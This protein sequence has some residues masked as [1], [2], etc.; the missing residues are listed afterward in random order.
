MNT[1]NFVISTVTKRKY[2]S[3]NAD[4]NQTVNCN[5]TNIVYLIT[6]NHCNL[7][8]IGQTGRRLKDRVSEHLKYI[9]K[10][11][12][13]CPLLTKHF[14]YEENCFDGGFSVSILEK[15]SG[16]GQTNAGVVDSQKVS[17]R[18]D[19]ESEW[20]KIIRSVYP[21][22]MNH[23]TGN[24]IYNENDVTGLIFNKL[25]IKNNRTKSNG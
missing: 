24:G 10:G 19:R 16:P 13:G 22:G 21:Y 4:L 2:K 3:V 7:Q 6:C 12:G 25:S 20:M 15:L 23:D 14:N 1:E 5:S 18:R 8:Y 17:G 11:R 9:R